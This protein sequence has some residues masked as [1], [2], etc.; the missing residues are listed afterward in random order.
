MLYKCRSK[1]HPRTGHEVS[2]GEQMYSSAVPST[3]ALDGGGCSKPQPG[4]YTSGKDPV[5]IVQEA[6]WAPGS[7]WTGVTTLAH[8]GIRNP[9]RPVLTSRYTDCSIPALILTYS[10]HGAEYFLRS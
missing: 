8:T 1:V 5:P 9:D 3:S 10:L 2:E 4:R 7:F 6:G